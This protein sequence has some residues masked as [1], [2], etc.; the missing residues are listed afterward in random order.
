MPRDGAIILGDLVGKLATL[1]IACA[2]CGRNGRYAVARLV[3]SRGADAK[4]S[5]LLD[6]IAAD[7]PRRKAANFSDMCGARC[8]ELARVM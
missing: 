2:K 1:A 8:P 6:E 5:D 4:V 7:C 3:D